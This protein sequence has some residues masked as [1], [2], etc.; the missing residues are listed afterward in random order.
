[1]KYNLW[2]EKEFVGFDCS[3]DAEVFYGHKNKSFILDDNTI[4]DV[5]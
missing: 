3:K 4:I 1:M 2:K 5:D